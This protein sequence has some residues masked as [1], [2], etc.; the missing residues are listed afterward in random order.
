MLVHA[1]LLEMEAGRVGV[2]R[3]AKPE[4]RGPV[5]GV[6][7]RLQNEQ[8]VPGRQPLDVLDLPAGE[9]RLELLAQLGDVPRRERGR[10]A[11]SVAGQASSSFTL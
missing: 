11:G 5:P 3:E 9:E 8:D 2:G 7:R 6:A 1:S 10:L 4:H